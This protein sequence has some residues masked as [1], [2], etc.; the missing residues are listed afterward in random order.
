VVAQGPPAQIVKRKK[1]SH[2]GRVLEG[3]LRE[4]TSP[5][6]GGT[7]RVAARLAA[8][9]AAIASEAAVPAR[10]RRAAAAAVAKAAKVTRR[11]RPEKRA[12]KAATKRKR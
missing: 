2:T 7:A 1:D 5:A 6:S 8:P 12:R 11:A 10:A 4:R 3:F 9:A